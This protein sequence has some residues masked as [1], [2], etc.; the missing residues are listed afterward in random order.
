MLCDKYGDKLLKIMPQNIKYFEK[1]IRDGIEECIKKHANKTDIIKMMSNPFAFYNTEDKD[2]ND[3]S[4]NDSEDDNDDI[5]ASRKKYD[6]DDPDEKNILKRLIK[7][8]LN[9]L[10][11][12]IVMIM[13]EKRKKK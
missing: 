5:L 7:T 9:M 10:K 11:W 3:D 4:N 13:R 12:L 2:S 8:L 1:P 6:S